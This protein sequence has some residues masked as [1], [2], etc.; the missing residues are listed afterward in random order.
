MWKLHLK[1]NKRSVQWHMKKWKYWHV[2]LLTL[3]T[4]PLMQYLCQIFAVKCCSNHPQIQK[5]KGMLSSEIWAQKF[6]HLLLHFNE[7]SLCVWNSSADPTRTFLTR[8]SHVWLTP[9]TEKKKKLSSSEGLRL[10]SL[11]FAAW[12]LS[13]VQELQIWLRFVTGCSTLSTSCQ[14]HNTSYS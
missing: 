10:F 13:P 7:F 5:L 4:F 14:H 2:C 6:S 1:L 11:V 8:P 9:I 3:F 12:F